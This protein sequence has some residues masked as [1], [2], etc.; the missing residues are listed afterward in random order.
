MGT[1][2]RAFRRIVELR[3]SGEWSALLELCQTEMK[4]TPE[5]L[6]PFMF[7]GIANAN[8]GHHERAVELL[9]HVQENAAGDPEYA[10]VDSLLQRLGAD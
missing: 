5:W 2:S 4:S 7:A 6:T 3:D 10:E 8:L 1:K 9:R